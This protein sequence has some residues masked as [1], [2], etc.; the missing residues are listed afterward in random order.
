VPI[1]ASRTDRSEATKT[2]RTSKTITVAY[3]TAIQRKNFFNGQEGPGTDKPSDHLSMLKIPPVVGHGYGGFQS[4]LTSSMKK[5][6]KLRARQLMK[7][8]ATGKKVTDGS[9]A[10]MTRKVK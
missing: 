2:F 6:V 3:V 4:K 7:R 9:K 1:I 5:S 8:R 10:P